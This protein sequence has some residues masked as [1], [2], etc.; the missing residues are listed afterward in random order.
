MA[1]IPTYC[2][3]QCRKSGSEFTDNNGYSYIY[4]RKSQELCIAQRWCSEQEKY[5]I[6]ERAN[7]TCRNYE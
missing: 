2:K 5:I 7:K 1:F 6:S 3:Y 4:C